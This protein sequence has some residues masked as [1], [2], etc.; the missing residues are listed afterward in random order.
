MS[1]IFFSSD[2]HFYHFNVIRYSGRPYE[3]VEEMNEALV[4]NWNSVVGPDDIVYYLGDFSLA[5]RAVEVFSSR[6]NGIKYLVPGNHD[7]CHTYNKK[8]RDPEKCAHWIEKYKEHGWNVLPMQT[9]LE[10]EGVG[11]VNMCH[12]PYTIQAPYDDKYEKWRP[13]ND[14]KWLICGHV[15]ETWKI[16][17]RMI[18]VGVDVFN[19][20]PVSLDEIKKIILGSE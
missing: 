20:T 4:A 3:T 5:F 10:I 19:Q 17:D 14:G 13:H 12:H 11:T 18:N 15:H 2:H 6:L 7:W 1:K 16:K 8:A 9:T